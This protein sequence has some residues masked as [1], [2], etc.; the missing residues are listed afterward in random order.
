ME[1]YEINDKNAEVQNSCVITQVAIEAYHFFDEASHD[2]EIVEILKIR[3][4]IHVGLG[5]GR[6]SA[7]RGINSKAGGT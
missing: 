4:I 2:E 1:K 7:E 6:V 5:T 3:R